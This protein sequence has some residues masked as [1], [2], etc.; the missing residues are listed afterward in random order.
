MNNMQ[1]E[2]LGTGGAIATPVPGMTD[3]LNVKARILGVPYSRYGP[4]IF[5]HGPDLL[6]DTPEEARLALDRANIAHV[7]N[8]IYSH[9]HPDHVLGRRIFELNRDWGE[10]PDH[11]FCTEV[12]LPQQVAVDARVHQGLYETLSFLQSKGLLTIHEL[13]DGESITL[14]DVTVQPFRLAQSYAYAFML[15]E[16]G[17]RVL[18]AADELYAWQPPPYTHDVDLAIVPTG[19]FQINPGTGHRRIPANHP[20]FD[21]EATFEQTLAMVEHMRPKRVIF[22]HIEA[23]DMVDHDELQD[24][25]STLTAEGKY[26]DVM[27]AWDTLRITT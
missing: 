24:L 23:V 12:Y 19:V 8:C 7:P 10:W 27:F 14:K 3:P 1:I 21:S 9:W 11:P 26:G 6:I 20:I 18:I 4:C 22:T 2:F 15:C 5:V 25:A 17:K 16:N 13:V